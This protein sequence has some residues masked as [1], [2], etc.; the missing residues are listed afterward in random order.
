MS[1]P[2][3]RDPRLE[4]A[5]ERMDRP[6][7]G[8]A[9]VAMV[10]YLLDIRGVAEGWPRA[11]LTLLTFVIDAVFAFDLA[12]KIFALGHEYTRTPWF[13]ID[14]LSCLPL[15]DTLTSGLLPFRSVRVFRGFR[16]L[17]MF[18]GLRV[19]RAL[20]SVPGF[21]R[22]SRDAHATGANRKAHRA[23]NLGM[24]ALT[25]AM[26]VAIVFVR[27]S[28]ER[29]HLHRIKV[30][31]A[32]GLTPAHLT[33]LGGSLR[34]TDDV[35]LRRPAL[36]NGR[37]TVVYF[38]LR[39]IDRRV[40]EFEF[41]M[42][43]GMMFSMV[44]FMYIMGYHHMEVTETQLRGLLNLALP[45][46]VAEQFLKDPDAYAQKTREPATI[47][48][49]DFVG[50]TRICES[51]AHQPDRLSAHLEG[52]MDRI[53]G[54][55]ARHDMII[56]KFIGDAVMTFRGGPLVPGTPDE[57]ARR[58]VRAALDSTAA[59]AALNDPFFRRV[60][61]GGASGSDCLIGAFGTSAR[62]SYTILGDGVNLAAR[63]EPACG[64]CGTQNLFDEST[65]RLCGSDAGFLWRRWG[66]VRVAGKSEPAQVYEAFEPALVADASFLD[67]F[68][69]ALHAYESH[70]LAGARELFLLADSQRP[71][72]DE[73]SRLYAGRC[74]ALLLHGLPE[75]WVPVF[76]THK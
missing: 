71:G 19:L 64:Q 41:F 49:M 29:E 33:D 24:L 23:M 28:L 21:E 40:D 6:L 48:F 36:V 52:A 1:E 62:L 9:V 30:A 4:T 39:A 34:P 12:L 67:T 38:D 45:R 20:R 69:R 50:F 56:D 17:R 26:I 35:V 72:G 32:E 2:R 43:M 46:Q 31:I 57:H 18:R 54:E 15:L 42:T 66:R 16:I 53:V 51:L 10:L 65:F 59:L 60:K 13:L 22:F 75:G 27:R 25:C 37:P 76:D 11:V 73:P 68:G 14:L 70:D 74:E 8:L 61:I 58:C 5:I 7:L 3:A 55:L 63:L 47:L 44:I